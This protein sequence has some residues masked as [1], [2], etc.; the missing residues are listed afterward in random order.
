MH[1]PGVAQIQ[2]YPGPEIGGRE[3][4]GEVSGRRRSDGAC[5]FRWA[6]RGPIFWGG[7]MAVF[8]LGLRVLLF[9]E[10]DSFTFCAE[11]ATAPFSQ[12]FSPNQE[13]VFRVSVVLYAKRRLRHSFIYS[14]CRYESIDILASGLV[15]PAT[16]GHPHVALARAGRFTEDLGKQVVESL[17]C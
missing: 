6:G 17:A 1:T 3:E 9:C 2:L 14:Y 10:G 16:S 8:P 5:W 13:F 7:P 15:R 11:I 4:L 12:H